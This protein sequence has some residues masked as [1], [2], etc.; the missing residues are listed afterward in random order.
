MTDF[1]RRIFRRR[2]HEEKPP[3]CTVIVAA[4]GSSTRMG[5]EDKIMADLLGEPVIVHTLRA[6]EDCGRIN[7]IIVVTRSELILPI[8]E[9]ARR[10]GFSKL[11]KIIEGGETRTHSVRL[12][13]LEADGQAELIAVHDGAR[14]LVTQEVLEKVIRSAETTNASTPAVPVKDTIKRAVDGVVDSTPKRQYLYA[15]QTPQVFSAD[16]IKAALQRAINDGAT[17]TDDCSV[18]ERLGVRVTLTKGSEENIK[19]TTP[20]DLAIAAA[21]LQWRDSR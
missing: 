21:I 2:R 16:L 3:F 15:V 10:A 5:G 14:P 7:E 20:V 18:V 4:A 9:A 6:L 8:G 11:T 17:V 12:G 19:I 1:L 13:T